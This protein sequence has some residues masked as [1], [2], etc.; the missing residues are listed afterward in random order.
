M[1]TSSVPAEM[2]LYIG[3]VLVGLWIAYRFYVSFVVNKKEGFANMVTGQ[4][5]ASASSSYKFVMYYADW[6][7]HCQRTKPEFAKLGATQTI[8][9]K[10][11]AVEAVNPESNPE[12]VEGKNIRGYP[13]IHLYDPKGVLVQEYEGERTSESFVQFLSQ[14]VK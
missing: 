13:T 5:S 4:A 7:G 2:A 10:Q 12:A 3:L 11:V 9:G 14:N 6:C 8:G 1:A